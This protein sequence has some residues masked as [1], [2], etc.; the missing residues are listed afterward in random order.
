MDA[1]C[2]SALLNLMSLVVSKRAPL[3]VWKG[4]VLFVVVLIKRVFRSVL[5]LM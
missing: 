5:A 4:R 3:P 1:F 2:G